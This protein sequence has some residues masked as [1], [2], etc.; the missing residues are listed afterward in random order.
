MVRE[1][2]YLLKADRKCNRSRTVT[3]DFWVCN[4][5]IP[6]VTREDELILGQIIG[7]AAFLFSAYK[8]RLRSSRAR[9]FSGPVSSVQRSF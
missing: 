6:F 4:G 7:L 1:A 3:Y 8:Y 2:P 5:T 9:A